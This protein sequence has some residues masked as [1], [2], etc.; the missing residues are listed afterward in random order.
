V[1]G[2]KYVLFK[3]RKTAEIT[4]D[5]AISFP[6]VV[7]KSC[8]LAALENLKVTIILGKLFLKCDLSNNAAIYLFYCS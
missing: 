2:H 1:F 4:K 7:E 3:G 5:A 6:F 8:A